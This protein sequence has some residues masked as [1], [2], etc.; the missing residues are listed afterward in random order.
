MHHLTVASVKKYFSVLFQLTFNCL[1]L[2]YSVAL[3]L[4]VES[5]WQDAWQGMGKSSS[6]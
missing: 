2:W 5:I 4:C 6:H 1:A 3:S